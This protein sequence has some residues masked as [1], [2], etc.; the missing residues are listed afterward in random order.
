MS[1]IGGQQVSFSFQVGLTKDKVTVDSTDLTLKSIKTLA[2]TFINEKFPDH[3]ITRIGERLMVFRHDYANTDNILQ[4]RDTLKKE[5]KLGHLPNI[6]W[7]PEA[8]GHSWNAIY[9]FLN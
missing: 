2:C 5:P 8:P 1:E 3:E 9:N 6:C 7:Y 4:V